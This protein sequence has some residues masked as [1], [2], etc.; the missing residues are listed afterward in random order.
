MC[1]W[2]GPEFVE[3]FTS[4]ESFAPN[5]GHIYQGIAT[6]DNFR[7]LRTR[8]EVSPRSLKSNEWVTYAKGGASTLWVS[9]FSLV[10]LW[11]EDGR[12]I[13]ANAQQCYGSASRTVKNEDVF[14]KPG[15][16]YTQVTVKGFFARAL[17]EGA[18]FDM[19]GPLVLVKTGGLYRAL[20]ILSS[21]PIRAL[22]KLLTDCRQ[23]H[24]TNLMRLPYP[25]ELEEEPAASLELAVRRLVSI[26]Q[27]PL[28]HDEIS[29]LFCSPSINHR[30]FEN[31]NQFANIVDSVV[32]KSFGVNLAD[33]RELDLL[34][35][36]Q[37]ADIDEDAESE[38]SINSK[39]DLV[40]YVVGCSFGRWDIRFTTGEKSAPQLPDPFAALPVCSP[41]VLQNE[42]DLPLS[43]DD[44]RRLR[45]AG[46][47]TYPLEIPW[48]GVLVDDAG[49]S[50]DFEVRVRQVLGI[51][52]TARADT[53]EQE[54]CEIL[55]YKSLRDYFRKPSGFFNDHLKRYS[56]SRRQAPIYWPLSTRSGSYTLWLYYPRLSSQTLH[57]C[58]ADFLDPKLKN[59]SDQIRAARQLKDSETRIGELL[60]FEDELKEMRTEV[61]RLI[62]LPY[63]PNLNDGVLITASPLWKL[64]RFPK[65]QKDLKACWQELGRG[66]YDWAHLAYSIWPDRVREKCKSDRSV[67]IA[68]GLERLC[69]VEAP[70][71]KTKRSRE[72]EE[73]TLVEEDTK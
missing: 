68:H 3:L 33:F 13:K 10:V 55:G 1:Y 18:V 45:G 17:P 58:L 42:K 54:T 14:F 72:T 32:A 69:S 29:S 35:Q 67:A 4:H 27:Q 34:L 40:M 37:V 53:I 9:D 23:W 52:W 5:N 22:A 20:G 21:L 71:T 30:V 56:R 50:L 48:G 7:F 62:K 65:W 47:W 49:H 15:L 2:A 70:K 73:A 64:F 44:V 57:T 28:R 38:D 25:N 43:Q 66:D 11:S 12:E 39:V 63:E 59:V 61:D 24:P 51:I 41:G 60:E 36:A 8:W 16:T 19:K 26:R 46:T 31:E 6:G